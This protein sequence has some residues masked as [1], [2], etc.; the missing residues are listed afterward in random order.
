M[1][2]IENGTKVRSAI[3]SCV[4]L[5]CSRDIVFEPIRFA[6]TAKQYSMSAI[7]HETRMTIQ[8]GAF[9]KLFRCPYQA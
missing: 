3:A 2:T 6:G 9:P 1:T 8:S 7:D 5:S 4:I